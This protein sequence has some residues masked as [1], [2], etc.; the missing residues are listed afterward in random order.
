MTTLETYGDVTLDK[1]ITYSDNI[2]FAKQALNMGRDAFTK[3]LDTVGFG[4]TLPFT[5]GLGTSS[6]GSLKGE[7]R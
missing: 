6:Y 5:L 2:Y 4:E 1:A 3:G 7:L